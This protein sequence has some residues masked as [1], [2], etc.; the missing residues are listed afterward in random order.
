MQAH[1]VEAKNRLS[2][3]R[4][5]RFGCIWMGGLGGAIAV[6]SLLT[7]TVSMAIVLLSF[8]MIPVSVVTQALVNARHWNTATLFFAW[9]NWC[10]AAAT[11]WYSGGMVSKA[12]M[13]FPVWVTITAWLLGVRH[14]LVM[15]GASALALLDYLNASSKEPMA[16]DVTLNGFGRTKSLLKLA[17]E[18]PFL[19]MTLALGAL[20]LMLAVGAIR[21]FGAGIRAGLDLEAR[22]SLPLATAGGPRG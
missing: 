9:G 12:T 3:R 18:P 4:L 6:I 19:A 14:A 11:V 13:A 20:V 21:R 22:P 8:L 5:L 10:L 2:M 16:F 17:F 1:F 7:P 15:M